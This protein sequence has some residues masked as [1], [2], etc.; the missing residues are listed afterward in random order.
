MLCHS[1]AQSKNLL[2]KLNEVI[3]R[4]KIFSVLLIDV[5]R[6]ASVKIQDIQPLDSQFFRLPARM[7][8]ALLNL[9]PNTDSY[10]IEA[11]ICCRYW[12]DQKQ[13]TVQD[14]PCEYVKI[15]E[16]TYD[17]LLAV[18]LC[19]SSAQSMALSRASDVQLAVWSCYSFD[20]IVVFRLRSL[21]EKEEKKSL[22]LVYG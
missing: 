8:R 22:R 6:T 9:I 20:R 15:N 13:F 7:N 21:K 14:S 10:S 5:G 18:W 12:L 19:H 4:S 1:S 2:S 16:H 11:I 3:H 17:V